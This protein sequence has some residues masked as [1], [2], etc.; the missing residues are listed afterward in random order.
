MAEKAKEE[1]QEKMKKFKYVELSML[2]LSFL[3][4]FDF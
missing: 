3:T 2:K 4:L 1:Y